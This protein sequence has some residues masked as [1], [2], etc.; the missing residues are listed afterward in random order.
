MRNLS[1]VKKEER[2]CPSAPYRCNWWGSPM[3]APSV[4]LGRE[5]GCSVTFFFK[6][7]PPFFFLFLIQ[8]VNFSW[9]FQKHFLEGALLSRGRGAW[10]TCRLRPLVNFALG[11]TIMKIKLSENCFSCCMNSPFCQH[12]TSM[13]GDQINSILNWFRNIFH[14]KATVSMLHE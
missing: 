3:Q 12:Y 14:R 2:R 6:F 9:F 5:N 11:T 13:T 4:E 7:F 8:F 1:P 10:G